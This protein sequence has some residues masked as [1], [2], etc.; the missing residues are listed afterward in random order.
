[1]AVTEHQLTAYERWVSTH[2]PDSLIAV[3][4]WERRYGSYYFVLLDLTGR[5][6]EADANGVIM[7]KGSDGEFPTLESFVQ[8]TRVVIPWRS[9]RATLDELRYL[10]VEAEKEAAD[11]SPTTDELLQLVDDPLSKRLKSA[12]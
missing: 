9:E 8:Y 6:P 10:P 5:D 4:G 3:V 11:Q 12:G 2:T 7:F 1:M